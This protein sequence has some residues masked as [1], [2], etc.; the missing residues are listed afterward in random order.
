MNR[1]DFRTISDFRKRHLEALAGLFQ[2]VLQLC[3]RAGLVDFGQVA[4]GSAEAG[5]RSE[6]PD[7]GRELNHQ[8]P[9]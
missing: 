8:R 3:R 9:S 4:L 5:Y 1:P 2:Q 6:H 7:D